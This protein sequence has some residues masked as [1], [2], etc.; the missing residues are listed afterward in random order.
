MKVAV[1]T[2]HAVANYGSLLQ[3]I[4]TQKVIEELGHSCEIIDYVREDEDY[5]QVEKSLLKRKPRWDSNP[6]KR[7]L[8]LR[9]DSQKV[10]W[11]AENLK[12]NR[13]NI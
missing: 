12:K 11:Q 10:S 7:G 2:R 6:V 3:A 1:I 8:Y 5:R 13:R 9:S 4:A